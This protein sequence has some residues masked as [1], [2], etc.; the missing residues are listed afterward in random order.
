MKDLAELVNNFPKGFL[1]RNRME[2]SRNSDLP[3]RGSPANQCNGCIG[4]HPMVNQ[5]VGDNRQVFNSHQEYQGADS[6]GKRF[7]VN[8]GFFF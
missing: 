4:V 1:F 8:A 5:P 6:F 3:G 2:C 7:P